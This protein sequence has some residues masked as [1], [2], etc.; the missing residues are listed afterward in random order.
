MIFGVMFMEIIQIDLGLVNCYLGKQ[1]DTF[2]LFDTGGHITMDRSF[3]NRRELLEIELKKAGCTSDNLKLVVLTHGDNDHVA[4]AKFIKEK[5]NTKIAMHS[6]DVELVDNPNFQKLME[7]YNY[8]SFLYKNVFKLLKGKIEKITKKVLEDY[9]DF[10][11]DILL[12]D[13][14]NLLEYGFDAKIIYVPGHTKGSIAILSSEGHLIVGDT[15]TNNKKPAA[16][17]NAVDFQK[18]KKSIE[19]LCST[20]S[21][22]VYPGHGKPF[23]M[24]QL[25]NI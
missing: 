2:I 1:G 4:N 11:P 21:K 24:N 23:E 8:K 15:L 16:A 14:D 17:P 6:A 9:E 5:Y 20:N 22:L 25:K 12:N 18:L 13:G 10:K 7:S 3:T 19:K